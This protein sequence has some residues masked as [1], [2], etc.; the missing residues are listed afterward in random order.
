[1]PT[2]STNDLKKGM[3]LDLPDGLFQVVDF[4]HVKPGKGGAFVRTTLRNARSGAQQDKTFRADEKVNQALIDK[5]E[6]QFLYRDG[7]DFVF[8]DNASYEQLH[9]GKSALGGS[10]RYIVDGSTVQLQMYGD[11]IVGTDLPAA[12]DLTVAST[13]PG[14]QG[15]R[16]S[17]ARKAATLET[18]IVVQVPLFVNEGE[19]IRVDTR[20]GEYITPARDPC[21]R[22]PGSAGAGTGSALRGRDEGLCREATCSPTCHCLRR[23][24][25]RRSCALST[26]IGDAIDG[27][28]SRFAH[29][30]SLE[31]MAAL[32][33]AALRM[34]T[35]ELIDQPEV[36]TGVVLAETV[37]LASRFSTDGSGRF[38]NGL[39]ARIADEVRPNGAEPA[40]TRE[41]DA[42]V[43]DLDGVLRLWDLDGIPRAEK[44]LGLPVG[45]ISCV[46]FEPQRL[47]RAMDGRLTF[48]DWDAEIGAAVA[49]EHGVSPDAVAEAFAD[50]P[51]RIN[52]DVLDAIRAVRDKGVPV[53]LL[54]NA[55]TRLRSELADAGL[56][57]ELDVIVSSADIGVAK[58]DPEAFRHIAELLGV[59]V[60]RCAFVDDMIVNVEAAA[61]LGMRAEHYRDP[62]GFRRFLTELGLGMTVSSAFPG[63]AGRAVGVP[64][65]RRPRWVAPPL[66]LRRSHRRQRLRRWTDGSQLTVALPLPDPP[67]ADD[68]V[69]LRTCAR[70]M[71]AR[72]S[73]PGRTPRSPAG[74]RHRPMP[75][76]RPRSAGS[77][78]RRIAASAA[79]HSTWPSS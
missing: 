10:A 2:V 56:A 12:V 48:E 38:V 79:W 11:E 24:T 73:A 25:R 18:G 9:V 6:M 34:G 70:R 54:S 39:L 20:S 74:A 41:V 44:A 1:M 60:E 64:R 57:D 33:R 14:V 46:A 32:D 40:P 37:E 71:R 21:H 13:E 68:V 42:L 63:H 52:L 30:W 47:A 8:M 58:P 67:L 26:S 75:R 19:R 55:S 78:P 43:V 50:T 76:R 53:G 69:E 23:L 7:E 66:A 27:L 62:D 65:P 51:W 35:A 77:G 49:A 36:P 16:V 72:W 31:R 15:D 29:G 45:A 17:G 4:Q 3:T 59:P 61:E 22:A 28:I 5:K